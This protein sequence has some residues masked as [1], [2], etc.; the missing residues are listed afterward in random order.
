[1]MITYRQVMRNVALVIRL[2]YRT[3]HTP[4][5]HTGVRSWVASC[6]QQQPARYSGR[7]ATGCTNRFDTWDGTRFPASST[8]TVLSN[9]IQGAERPER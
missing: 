2:R 4:M 6:W 3:K 8:Q 7:P 5:T 9:G 1:M